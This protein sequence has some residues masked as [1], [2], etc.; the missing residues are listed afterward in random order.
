MAHR[1]EGN[2][3]HSLPENVARKIAAGEV[4]DRP[5]AILREMLDNAVDSGATRIIS[6]IKNGG[7][8]SIRVVDNGCGM[9]KE[10]LQNCA[11]PHATSK[12]VTEKDLD[13]LSTLG[14]RGEALAS[15]AAVSRL[16]IQTARKNTGSWK[17]EVTVGKKH[18]IVPSY[19]DSGTIVHSQ[20][21]FENF[22]ARR[23]FLKRPGTESNMCR[24]TFIEKVIPYPDIAFRLIIDNKI[25]LDL[26]KDQTLISR[27]INAIDCKYDTNLF[28]EI[29]AFDTENETPQWKI[30]IVLSPPEISRPD[31]KHMYIFV[32]GRRIQEYSMLQAIDYGAQGFYPN[33]THPICALFIEMNPHLV[34]FNIHPA[35]KEVRFK[36]STPIH[37]AV[38]T[39]VRSFYHAHTI[40]NLAQE[41]NLQRPLEF[42]NKIKSSDSALTKKHEKTSNTSLY[43]EVFESPTPNKTEHNFTDT[44][45]KFERKFRENVSNPVTVSSNTSPFTK[46][47]WN[48]VGQ[49]LGVFL[50]VEKN[51][52]LLLVDQHAGHERIRYNDFMENA[53][54][55]QKL[56]IP[57][58]LETSEPEE[59][60]Y[61]KKIT[62][63]LSDAGFDIK[64]CGAGHWEISSVPIK[65]E[66][67]EGDL[68]K[69]LLEKRLAPNEVIRAIAATT[70]CRGAIKDGNILD[71]TTAEKLLDKIF[72]L[73]EPFCPHGRPIW[74][75]IT[76]QE[77]FDRVHR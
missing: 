12:I 2:P 51:N 70:A 71:R 11:Y 57:F 77:L 17:V 50:I 34:D 68:Q 21:L 75:T 60:N 66:G 48:Y 22:P 1:G 45:K 7:I 42:R 30:T 15:I 73:E 39:T 49:A 74:T 52:E 13:N 31:K 10:D 44:Y 46:R 19:L 32:N 40:K 28:S 9:T 63:S 6:E 14:F 16:S 64:D 61:L 53:G 8:D 72:A 33:G 55:K 38:S 23:Q 26:P 36:N 76:K 43:K 27:F 4:I 58:I 59:D 20:G 41:K 37:H 67:T 25:R 24:Q 54:K 5:N 47:D 69:S 3:V 29:H 65:W 62:K 56:L 18:E 35:K